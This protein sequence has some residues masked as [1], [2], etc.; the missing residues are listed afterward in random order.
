[1]KKLLVLAAGALAATAASLTLVST[2]VAGAAPDTSGQTFSE[3]QATLKTA[4]YTAVMST[5]IGDQVAQND[6]TV[7]RQQTTTGGAFVGGD[8]PGS[9]SSSPKVLL[10]LDCTK[11][12][13]S[14]PSH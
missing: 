13:K 12:P 8:W 1:M 4:G 14:A 2:G 6:C 7:V 5:T 10:T 3:A 9:S 11:A